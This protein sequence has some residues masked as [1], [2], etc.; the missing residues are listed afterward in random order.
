MITGYF[1]AYT[2]LTVRHNDNSPHSR[3]SMTACPQAG[4]SVHDVLLH[5]L[6]RG[7]GVQHPAGGLGADFLMDP[8]Q[9]CQR[10]GAPGGVQGG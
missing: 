3:Q 6:L 9:G 5:R 7:T 10:A 1:Q 2:T 4:E 8:L